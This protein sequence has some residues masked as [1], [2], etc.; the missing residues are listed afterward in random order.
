[1]DTTQWPTEHDDGHAGDFGGVTDMSST[2]DEIAD[3]HR[4][5]LFRWGHVR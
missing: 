5:A 4:A 1:M 2:V 3:H